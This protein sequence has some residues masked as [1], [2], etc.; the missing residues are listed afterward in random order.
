M[1]LEVAQPRNGKMMEVNTFEIAPKMVE[2]ENGCYYAV[3]GS[4]EVLS[5]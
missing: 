5:E 2:G 4:S 3:D 1:E